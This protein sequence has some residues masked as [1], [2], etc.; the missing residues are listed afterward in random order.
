MAGLN[1]PH[2]QAASLRCS[3]AATWLIAFKP[4]REAGALLRPS[5]YFGARFSYRVDVNPALVR[6][7]GFGYPG[8]ATTPTLSRVSTTVAIQIVAL[9]QALL[10]RWMRWR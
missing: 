7:I 9:L 4:T 5:A 6:M 1:A 3:V 10:T 8:P 2:L